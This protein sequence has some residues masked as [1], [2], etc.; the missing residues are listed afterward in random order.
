MALRILNSPWIRIR[1]NT[2][3]NEY[4]LR[5]CYEL[6]EEKLYKSPDPVDYKPFAA[7]ENPVNDFVS[8]K[9]VVEEDSEEAKPKSYGR[10]GGDDEDEKKDDKTAVDFGMKDL[11]K[12]FQAVVEYAFDPRHGRG[13]SPRLYAAKALFYA[14]KGDL[15]TVEEILSHIKNNMTAPVV[16]EFLSN[17]G[18]GSTY[19]TKPLSLDDILPTAHLAAGNPQA[20]LDAITSTNADLNN[21]RVRRV[22]V[23][24]LLA[25]GREAEA[26]QS[27]RDSGDVNQ[28]QLIQTHLG[29]HNAVDK[30]RSIYQQL[31]AE[32]VSINKET[33]KYL[34]TFDSLLPPRPAEPA[35]EEAKPDEE[36]TA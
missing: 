16:K 18:D 8:P 23:A 28:H 26:L 7:V 9:K 20:A 31:E 32:G 29:N 30:I 6:Q 17:K 11:D 36:A 21:I 15:K 12:T 24:A 3:S 2:N 14:A 5:I 1:P 25:L 13:I 34:Q 35:A 4:L 19:K 10:H 27:I 22:H 33:K